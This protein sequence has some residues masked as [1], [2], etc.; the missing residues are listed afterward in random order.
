MF[1]SLFFGLIFLGVLDC[2][3]GDIEKQGDNQCKVALLII[4]VQNFFVGGSLAVENAN[5]IIPL[6]NQIRN[7]DEEFYDIVVHSQDWHPPAHVSFFSAHQGTLDH[8]CTPDCTEQST[9]P[10]KCRKAELFKPFTLQTCSEQMLWPD[11]CIQNTH[12]SQ[13]APGLITEKTDILIKK[14]KQQNVDSYSA[15]FDNDGVSKTELDSILKRN[16][17]TTIV[18][19]GLALDYCV[20]F[21]AIDAR[22]LGFEV[23]VVE[24]ATRGV[25]LE[26]VEQRKD[27]MVEAGVKIINSEQLAKREF[28]C[29]ENYTSY[30]QVG[31]NFF[32]SVY[33][34][35][36]GIDESHQNSEF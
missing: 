14:G 10:K 36:M 15:F 12:G 20:G 7:Q 16:E 24:N 27:E 8:S 31:V 4:D 18:M 26:S 33:L 2:L 3:L 32:Q 23:F 6:I 34:W 28:V 19:V 21:S 25:S 35:L 11:H 13:F 29:S 22:K 5:E 9:T 30:F 17:I 1:K